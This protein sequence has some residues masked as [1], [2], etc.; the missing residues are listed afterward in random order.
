MKVF[1][2]LAIT[3]MTGA[4]GT[5]GLRAQTAPDPAVEPAA[6]E[7]LNRMGAFLRTLKSFQVT[8]TVTDE[9][10]LTDGQK[11]QN[12]SVTNIVARMP[13]RLFGTTLGDRQDRLFFYNGKSFTLFARRAGYYATIDA[14]SDIGKLALLLAEKYD[15]EI[16][17]ED[18]F[19]WGT[20]QLN[21]PAITAATD[22]GPSVVGGVTCQ[23]YAFR[24]PG[25][26]WQIWIQKGDSPLPRKLV[27]T[28]LTDEARPQHVSILNW[29]LAPSFDEAAFTFYPPDNVQRIV[30]AESK[31]AAN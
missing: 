12:S 21:V 29:D 15:L 31:A 27:L 4:L 8:A 26:D 6:I 14:P 11:L 3:L 25:L 23:H 24:Q 2:L 13:D 18:L 9:D 7:A 1:P 30:F 19:F 10:V 22:A 28:T 5:L 17:L 20:A 16:P